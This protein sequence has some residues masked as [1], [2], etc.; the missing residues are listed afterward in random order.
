MCARAKVRD[1]HVANRPVDAAI[2]VTLDGRKDV[3]GLWMG[4]GGEGAK[5]WMS[6]LVDLKTEGVTAM[7][8]S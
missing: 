6:I 4:A 1:G 8:R 2:G 3:L 5:F 7:P